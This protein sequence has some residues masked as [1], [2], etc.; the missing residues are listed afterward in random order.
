MLTQASP[1]MPIMPRLSGCDAGR[2]PMPSSVAATGMSPRSAKARSTASAPEIVT[3][4]PARITGRFAPGISSAA[5]ARSGSA[6]A[7]GAG[8][9]V[10][11]VGG[12]L[13]VPHQRVPDRIVEHRVVGGQNRAAGIAE[14]FGDAFAHQ[15][16][17]EDLRAGQ[18]LLHT[19]VPVLSSTAGAAAAVTAPSDAEPT[20]RAYFAMTPP[21]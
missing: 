8:I 12:A 14:D 4:W 16:L 2:P 7:A 1:C 21:A 20:S 13:L 6:G 10:G 3:P 5:R 11:H 18:L 15:A 9:A 19:V 17:P